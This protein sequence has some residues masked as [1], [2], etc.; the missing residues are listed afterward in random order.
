MD[1]TT[2]SRGRAVSRT[3]AHMP[4]ISNMPRSVFDRSKRHTTTFDSGWIVPIYVDEI[5]PGDTVTMSTT[6]FIR[7]ATPLH[8]TM[9]N[10]YAD[11]FYFFV[12]N[13]L[14]YDNWQKLMGEQIDP[15][16][17]ISFATPIVN[18]TAAYAAQSLQDQMGIP[19]GVT[20][21][22]HNNLPMRGYNLIYNTWF[23]DQ[24]LQDSVPVPKGD[25]PDTA[26]DFVLKR[27]GKRHDYFTSCRPF[28]QKGTAASLP[29]GS[30]APLTILG[31]GAPTFDSAGGLLNEPMYAASGSSPQNVQMQDATTLGST[32]IMTWNTP[33]LTGTADLSAATAATINQLRDAIAL[34][35]FYERNARAG[36]RYVELIRAHFGVISP[37]QRLQNPEYLGGGSTRLSVH[38][39][40]ATTATPT[41]AVGDLGAFVTGGETMRSFNQ[42]FTE[43]G[44]IIG[45]VQVRADITYQ[46]GLDRMWSRR[47]REEFYFPDFAGLGE[48]T[49]L[50]KEIYLDGTAG[51]DN[52]FGYQE[53]YGEYRYARS[54]IAGKF[55]ST[56]PQTLDSWH[57][58]Q[59]FST[60]PTLGDTFIQ[61]TPPTQRVVVVQNEPEFLADFWFDVKHVRP[62]PMFGVPA[63][64]MGRM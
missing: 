37:D 1:Q 33:N 17:S 50:S 64:L 3:F 2:A 61:D 23:R 59:E 39:I 38:P 49:V 48:Q 28:A 52:V 30:T 41:S 40:S 24:D 54:T 53:R 62:M 8:P 16:D 4:E 60:R 46:Q 13:R 42:S 5:L 31:S 21:F 45:L 36:T 15:G 14:V 6:S 19:P 26:A 11:F 56:D 27:R 32:Q 55:R 63:G 18:V 22:E 9:D 12:P 58:S 10:M 34:Q 20:G 57:L 7:F 47:T 25:G 29:L 35:Q 51:D 44:Y 43:H